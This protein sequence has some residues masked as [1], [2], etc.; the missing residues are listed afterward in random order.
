MNIDVYGFL[1]IS[2]QERLEELVAVLGIRG[3]GK[4]NTAAVLMEE[5]LG[6]GL[7]IQVV[8]IRGEYF[9][10]KDK[11]ER[12]AVVGRGLFSE[13][14]VNINLDNAATVAETTYLNGVPTVFDL[15][16]I[17][18]DE[19]GHLLGAY[20][21]RIWKLAAANRIPTFVFLEEAHNL[22]PQVGKTAVSELF[23]KYA[24]EG[25]MHGLSAILVG[26]RAARINKNV[27]SQAGIL[28]LHK[29][30]APADMKVYE[31]MIDLP[32]QRIKGMVQRLKRGQA[33][34]ILGERPIQHTIRRRH[35]RHVGATPSLDNVPA[36]TQMSLLDLL[37]DKTHD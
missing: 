37:G 7:P 32:R 3:S 17:P 29:V 8:D 34:V 28:F 30:K 14:E 15:S 24:S 16:N 11:F 1:E 10:L 33:L 22:V 27:L 5:L 20:F 6:I 25:R 36:P 21:S 26:Q 2:P 13:P 19:W 23:V 35:T 31:A 9:T 12:V 18:S 4:T